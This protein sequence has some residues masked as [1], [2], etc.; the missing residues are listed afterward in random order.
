MAQFKLS[1]GIEITTF[2]PP[3]PG[4]DPLTAS[5]AM[6]RRH[7]FP[8]HLPEPRHQERYR[9]VW[10]QL[11][12]KFHYIQPT[13]RVNSE[14][15]HGPRKP[16][17]TEGTESSSNWSGA[18]VYAPAGTSF[19]WVQADWVVPNVDAPTQNQWYYCANWIGIDGDGSGDVC[20]AGVECDVF[21]SGG[22]ISR[23]IYAWHEW[24][25]DPE[26]QIT[27]LSVNAGDMITVVL[28]TP[29]G[30]GTG[31][32]VG[33]TTATIYITN[34]TTGASMSYN[35]SAPGGTKLVGNSAEWIVEAPQINGAQSA[36]ADYGQVFFDVCEGYPTKGAA[37]SGG[38]GNNINLNSGGIVSQG[39]LVS[40]NV[41][42]CL[43][44]GLLPA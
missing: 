34:R 23:N 1:E 11:K 44:S 5:A 18:V 40:P 6:L 41:V 14:K 36:I 25:P 42:E 17:K 3:P 15:K 4:F 8:P 31:G 22:S 21:R 33:S 27:N 7:G 26:V 16:L 12:G 28:C 24:Y 13:F 39:Y 37:V 30:A 2:E 35:F 19:K 20:Q 10:S 32:G 43:Y 29:Q 38:T 9:K